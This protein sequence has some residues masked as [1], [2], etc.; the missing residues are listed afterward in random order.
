M[1]ALI[2]DAGSGHNPHPNTTVLCDL[3]VKDNGHRSDGQALKVDTRPFVCC[4]LQALPFQTKVFDLVYS[5]H[6]IEHV[7][8]PER[9]LAELK[10]VGKH[11]K[12]VCPSLI[13]E[14][15]V[16]SHKMHKWIVK[17]DGSAKPLHGVYRCWG[18]LVRKIIG[19]FRIRLR[20]RLHLKRFY[21]HIIRW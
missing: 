20:E 1:E 7:A 11:G 5:S 2:L 6:V 18:L 21:E 4:D 15:C 16:G 9:A 19:R 13:R 14:V 3:F 8:D 17:E 12:I 10:R